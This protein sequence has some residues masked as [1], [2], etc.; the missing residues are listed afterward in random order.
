MTFRLPYYILLTL[1]FT[2]VNVG[3]MAQT[4]I[5]KGRIYNIENKQAIPEIAVA[6]KGVAGYTNTDS[7]GA[8][9]LT[10]PAEKEIT[11]VINRRC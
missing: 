1:I 8:Y 5:I 4:A 3:I 11:I 6:I 2:L 10:V 7:T 9:Q